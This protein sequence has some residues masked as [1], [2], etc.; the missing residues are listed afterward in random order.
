[1]I[2]WD[3]TNDIKEGERTGYGENDEMKFKCHYKNDKLD[4]KRT[5]WYENRQIKSESIYKDGECVSGDC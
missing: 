2:N 1:M 3:I 5:K 4:G